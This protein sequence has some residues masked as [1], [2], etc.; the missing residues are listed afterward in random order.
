MGDI[1]HD[2]FLDTLHH[3][4]PQSKDWHAKELK[5]KYTKGTKQNSQ[6]RMRLPMPR[7]RLRSIF[8]VTVTWHM[9]IHELLPLPVECFGFCISYSYTRL[10]KIYVRICVPYIFVLFDILYS[11]FTIYQRVIYWLSLVFPRINQGITYDIKQIITIKRIKTSS[12]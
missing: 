3:L 11:F 8:C 12:L 9:S 4:R 10:T 1:K 7:G 6:N 2:V 5:A